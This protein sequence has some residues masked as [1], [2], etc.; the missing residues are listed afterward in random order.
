MVYLGFER[1]RTFKRESCTGKCQRWKSRKVSNYCF[2]SL[3]IQRLLKFFRIF[4]EKILLKILHMLH[5][6]WVE[7]KWNPKEWKGKSGCQQHS[8]GINF[9]QINSSVPFWYPDHLPPS[10]WGRSFDSC[11][12]NR[13]NQNTPLLWLLEC[14]KKEKQYDCFN[15]YTF[16]KLKISQFSSVKALMKQSRTRRPAVN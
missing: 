9:W 6:H 13:A 3:L 2:L 10:G 5:Q 16:H 8:Y 11:A 15:F 14:S 1:G 12:E 4:L 7:K